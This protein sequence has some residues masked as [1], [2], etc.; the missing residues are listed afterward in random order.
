MIFGSVLIINVL[1]S[2]VYCKEKAVLEIVMHKITKNGEYKTEIEKIVGH[3]SAAGS[4]VSA[5]GNILQV[6]FY[7]CTP[8]TW[9]IFLS[10]VLCVVLYFAMRVALFIND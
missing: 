1:W 5:E 10:S 4:T 8:I 6:G 3:F 2:L 9:C 7:L